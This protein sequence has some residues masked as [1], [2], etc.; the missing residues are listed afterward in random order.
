MLANG[1][2]LAYR[3]K[4]DGA[5]SDVTTYTD[6]PGLK[7][8]PSIGIKKE[9]ADNTCLTDPHKKYESGIGDLPEMTYKFK[10]DNT[11]ADS[12]YRVMRKAAAANTLLQFKETLKDG[13]VTKYDATVG[14]TRTGGGINGVIEFELEMTVESDLDYEDPS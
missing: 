1:A 7:E 5:G 12:P 4:K 11:K 9:K 8:I 14:V 10:Y 13:S 2:T 6:L 3:E